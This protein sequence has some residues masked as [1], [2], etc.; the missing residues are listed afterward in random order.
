MKRDYLLDLM[1]SDRSVFTVREIAL[2]WEKFDEAFVRKKLFR[3]AK[4]EKLYQIRKG[5][6]A[7]IKDYNKFELAVRI[8]TPSYIGFETVLAKA[9][10]IFQYYSQI[11]LASYQ[12]REIECDG[13]KYSYLRIHNEILTNPSGLI[14]NPN[15]SIATTERALL[16]TIYRLREY[17]FDNLSPIDWDKVYNILP[18]YNGNKRMEKSISKYYREYK[19]SK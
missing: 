7:K 6:Y 3:Y 12:S 4:T 11:F 1:R 10:I 19:N 14:L 13:Q 9:G 16:D 8:Y 15:Y 2:I 17:H 18:I 5:I